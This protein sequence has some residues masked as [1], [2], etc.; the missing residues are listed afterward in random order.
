M[1]LMLKNFNDHKI[2]TGEVEIGYSVGPDNGPDLLL[3]HGV[4]SRRDSFL[5]VTDELVK[6]H[7][8][9][10]MDQRGH[11]FSGHTPGAYSREDHARDIR[12]VMDNVCRGDVIVWGHS[13][14]GGNALAMA[15]TRPGNLKAVLLEDPALFRPG[16]GQRPTNSPTV[17]LFRLYLSLLE[18]DLSL[19]EMEPEL[20]KANP[21]QPEF[22]GAWK[23]ES[24]TQMDREILENVVSGRARGGGDPTESL[25]RVDCPVLI[26]QADSDAGGILTDAHVAAIVPEK[27]N[28]AVKKIVGAGHNIH[29][30]HS[31]LLLPVA[32]PWLE[33]IGAS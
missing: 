22:F 29:R 10:A 8:V 26:C 13:M 5:M 19:E 6:N 21:N 25:N 28:I 32:L 4:T 3:L 20:R 15:A 30:E 16:P 1:P 24:L 11:G 31:E 17:R 14:G 23:A 33:S 12:F 18:K 27:D 2:D 7:R 9:I